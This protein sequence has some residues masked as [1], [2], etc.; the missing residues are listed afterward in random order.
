MK[1]FFKAVFSF[2]IWILAL[3]LIDESS[4]SQ[5]VTIKKISAGWYHVCVLKSDGSIKCRGANTSGQLGDGTYEDTPEKGVTN[6]VSGIGDAMDVSSGGSHT[7]AVLSNGN[8]KCWGWNAFGQLGNGPNIGPGPETCSDK[9][10]R[11]TYCS[12]T[13]ILVDGVNDAVAVDAGEEHTCALIK[14]GTIKCWGD[15]SSGQLGNGKNS[16][17]YS[18]GAVSV[19]DVE[20]AVGVSAGAQHTCALLSNGNIKCWGYNR[21][22]ILGDGTDKKDLPYSATP[23]PV[24][25]INNAT[26]I[27]AGAFYSCALI[28]DG[29]IKCW[30]SDMGGQLGNA[31][32]TRPERL[33]CLACSQFPV[34]VEGIKDALAIAAGSNHSCALLKNGDVKCWGTNVG[35][36]PIEME[37]MTATPIKVKD[38]TGAKQISAGAG[39][40]CIVF[41]D[42]VTVQCW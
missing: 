2:F 34:E 41:Q 23:I 24:K 29:S 39:F 11:V 16:S 9:L 26:S 27:S 42:D 32:Y 4:Y 38:I 21:D 10:N 19:L 37:R 30:G 8:V 13:P 22:F 18:A 6:P 36:L 3:S 17:K 7:C 1:L 35:K 25:N 31:T 14:D 20:N 40:S 5:E 33:I 12:K 15:N 28:S